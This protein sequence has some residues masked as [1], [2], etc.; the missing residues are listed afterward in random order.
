MQVTGTCYLPITD[1]PRLTTP[2][3]A[4]SAM[5]SICHWAWPLHLESDCDPIDGIVQAITLIRGSASL[6]LGTCEYLTH[7]PW[8]CGMTTDGRLGAWVAEGSLNAIMDQGEFAPEPLP[9]HVDEHLRWLTTQAKLPD[10]TDDEQQACIDAIVSLRG[11]LDLGFASNG[12]TDHAMRFPAEI[13]STYVDM[14]GARKPSAMMIL[15]YYAP[16]MNPGYWMFG[17]WSESLA[18]DVNRH[19]KGTVWERP[20]ADAGLRIQNEFLRMWAL[21][22]HSSAKWHP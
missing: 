4:F 19:M 3:F 13:S 14:L 1:T 17:G 12:M 11:A 2:S 6:T 22:P 7:H 21:Q 8:A 9:P 10:N 15:A 18:K 20:I 16:T 5:V